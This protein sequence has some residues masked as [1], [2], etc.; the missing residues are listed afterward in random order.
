MEKNIIKKIAQKA[1]VSM[2]SSGPYEWPPSCLI[3]TYQP[4]RP[5]TDMKH[6]SLV[7]LETDKEK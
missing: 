4:V 1:A 5:E 3:F 7:R 2:M 6:T